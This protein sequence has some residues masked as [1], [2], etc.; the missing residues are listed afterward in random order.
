MRNAS[1]ALIALLDSQTFITANLFT[2]TLANGTQ[3]FWT[4]ADIDVAVADQ[5]F[6][7]SGPSISGVKYRLVRGMQVSDLQLSVLAK[8]DDLIAG[9]PWFMATRSGALKN[10]HVRIDK[11]FMADWGQP[12]ESLL[13]FAGNVSESQDGD[14][15]VILTVVSDAKRLTEVIPRQVFQ[16]GCMRT[17]Y[18]TGC[19]VS[20]DAYTYHGTVVA[21]TNRY[22]FSGGLGQ[23]EGF[24]T[25]GEVIF[26]TG[27][28]AGVR[29]SVKSYEGGKVE[30]SYPL[31]F[32]LAPGD[33]FIV[34]AGCDR[35]RGPGG[36]AK[37]N[38]LDNFNGTP[39]V[40]PPE[41]A[42]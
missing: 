40:P 23:A 9:V 42:I 25:F 16:P 13:I 35:T 39:Y 18:D 26:E 41:N 12:A 28:N 14:L 3:Y 11:A 27:N 34:R 21:S 24:F 22:S 29:R 1:P 2:F 32:D 5:V 15:E 19:G 37:F 30:L 20:R 4:D 6:S 31:A 8:P 10:C 36:C 17:L 33:R 7:S 38:N